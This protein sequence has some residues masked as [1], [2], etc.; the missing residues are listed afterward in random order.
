ME[1]RPPV[2]QKPDTS[3]GFHPPYRADPGHLESSLRVARLDGALQRFELHPEWA[4][5]LRREAYLLN[6]HASTRIEGNRLSLERSRRVIERASQS[7]NRPSR[8]EELE[9]WQHYRWFERLGDHPPTPQGAPTRHEIVQTH[10]DLLT[11][12]LAPEVTGVLRSGEKAIEVYFG[13]NAGT[14]PDRVEDELTALH[15]W[16]QNEG[17]LQPLPVR[18]AIWVHEFLSIH[19]F[20]DGNGRVARA[21]AHRLLYTQGLPSSLFVALDK[22]FNERRDDYYDALD[23]AREGRDLGP[24]VDHFLSALETTYKEADLAFESFIGIKQ[25]LQGAERAVIDHVLQ[26]G[27]TRLVVT[28]T[29]QAVGY[30]P[31]TVSLAFKRLVDVHRL[32]VHN[33]RRGRA[34]AYHPSDRLYAALLK[35]RETGS[36][37]EP[38]AKTG[39]TTTP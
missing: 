24:W 35:S 10:I 20:E 14:P 18:I 16:Y 3:Q 33:G 13:R 4:A 17:R 7:D 23:A 21:L 38:A 6:T 34:S 25:G 22:P 26:T 11:G 15:A 27:E 31:V 5:H 8:V 9:V 32:L 39:P 36:S 28:P 29:A 30:R 2:R 12:V 37:P 1:A 19:P